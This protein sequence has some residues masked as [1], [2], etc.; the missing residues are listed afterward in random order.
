M[1]WSVGRGCRENIVLSPA[2]QWLNQRVL[3]VVGADDTPVRLARENLAFSETAVGGTSEYNLRVEN[4]SGSTLT[5]KVA[6]SNVPYVQVGGCVCVCGCV[7]VRVHT[8]VCACVCVH[9]CMCV[10]V[11]ASG[12]GH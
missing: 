12:A 6:R 8:C 5:W 4:T 10:C 2:F 7:C 3:V 1:A 9:V 11:C